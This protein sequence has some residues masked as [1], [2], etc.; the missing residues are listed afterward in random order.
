[1][2][3]FTLKRRFC[4]ATS[5]RT[6]SRTDSGRGPTMLMSPSSTLTSCGSSSTLVLRSQRPTRVILGSLRILK[7]GPVFSF[8]C[9]SSSWP[10]SASRRIVRNFNIR[11]R[12][13]FKPT[14]SCTKRIGPSESSLIAIAAITSNGATAKSSTAAE[15]RSKMRLASVRQLNNGALCIDTIGTPS[16]S[17]DCDRASFCGKRSDNMCVVIPCSS[18]ISTTVSICVY[19]DLI[20]SA[21]A[22]SSMTSL[23]TMRGRSSM[24]PSHGASP[25]SE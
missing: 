9:S 11:N 23:A 7:I 6:A 22:T 17:I 10:A 16:K 19:C 24:V 15:T 4:Q 14:R 21:I 12:R 8:R 1:M 25:A 5:I 18:S 2:P 3:G 13:L 20:G